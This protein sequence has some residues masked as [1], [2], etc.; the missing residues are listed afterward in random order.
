ME[1]VACKVIP[2]QRFPPPQ[3]RPV[4]PL[5]LA[6][7]RRLRPF[8]QPTTRCHVHAAIAT[9][10]MRLIGGDGQ[11]ARRR[12]HQQLEQRYGRHV[13]CAP[14]AWD[15]SSLDPTRRDAI[16]YNTV[17]YST[18]RPGQSNQSIFSVRLCGGGGG[19]GCGCS[20]DAA[21]STAP[22]ALMTPRAPSFPSLPP[23]PFPFPFLAFSLS[24]SLEHG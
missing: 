2:R 5:G 1:R 20:A 24:P 23:F 11:R 14:A 9:A 19:C 15:H 18:V 4:G 10:A 16:Q 22:T 12:Q 21:R 6:G 3:T 7:R 13:V 17:Q 8:A